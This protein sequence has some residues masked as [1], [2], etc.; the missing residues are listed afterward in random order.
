MNSLLSPSRCSDALCK[1]RACHAKSPFRYPGGKSF[2]ADY[3]RSKIEQSDGY[4][5]YAEPYAGGAGAG[6]KLLGDRVITRLRI[7]DA[8]TRVHAAWSAMLYENDR[9]LEALSSCRL[10][11]STWREQ[12]EI[13]NEPSKAS[14]NFDLGFATFFLNRTNRSGIIL[15]A[16]PI[17]GYA[18]S[19]NWT[20][21]ARFYRNT[22][23]ER[24]RWVGLNASKISLTNMDGLTFLRRAAKR[25]YS[26]RTLFFIDPPYV[27]AGSRLYLNAMNDRKHSG[28]AKFLKSGAISNWIV[29]YDDCPLID[30]LYEGEEKSRLDVLYSLQAKRTQKELL[31]TPK[32]ST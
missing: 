6:I 15:G 16:G 1:P 31:I 20:V 8:D 32:K 25:V 11:I 29:T 5:E 2:L 24:V 17:G 12:A 7:N 18:Q 14:S 28:L 22:L 27:G 3:I 13:V 9:F 21:G 10:D 26:S 4:T 30:E 19:G 23:I